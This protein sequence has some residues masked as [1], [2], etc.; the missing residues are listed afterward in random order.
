MTDI[1]SEHAPFCLSDVLAEEYEKL[2]GTQ[3]ELPPSAPKGPSKEEEE[4]APL[5]L[6]QHCRG[7]SAY[8]QPTPEEGAGH[9]VS[10]RTSF[11]V[12]L[13]HPISISTDRH[14]Q[15]KTEAPAQ[16]FPRVRLPQAHSQH[17]QNSSAELS[18]QYAR[19]EDDPRRENLFPRSR[20]GGA[21]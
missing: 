19:F 14:F 16:A 9:I 18:T 17:R 5:R 4:E 8:M 20:C 6:C 15:A 11:T 13:I 12:S 1:L 21:P 7:A 2:Y 3:I 10:T